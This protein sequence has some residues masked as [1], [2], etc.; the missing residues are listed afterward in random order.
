VIEYNKKQVIFEYLRRLDDN[1]KGIVKASI[2]AAK[3]VFIKSAPY[4]VRTI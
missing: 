4:R 2:E 1:G 3:L